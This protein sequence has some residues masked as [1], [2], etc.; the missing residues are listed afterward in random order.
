MASIKVTLVDVFEDG[1]G[2]PGTVF[3]DGVLFALDFLGELR[4]VSLDCRKRVTKKQ[5]SIAKW[6]YLAELKRRAD[7][8]WFELNSKMY[9]SM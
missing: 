9:T 8:S 4:C 6:A 5:V 1:S 2:A 7:A 3:V